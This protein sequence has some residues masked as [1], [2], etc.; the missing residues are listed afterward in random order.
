MGTELLLLRRRALMMADRTVF[1]TL[2]YID[3]AEVSMCCKDGSDGKGGTYQLTAVFSDGLTHSAT[4]TTSDASKATVNGSGLVSFSSATSF[5]DVT[6]S[7]SYRGVTKSCLLTVYATMP[8]YDTFGSG[9]WSC[10][11]G[12]GVGSFDFRKTIDT[13]VPTILH[14]NDVSSVII[15]DINTSI[16]S[17]SFY[18][19]PGIVDYQINQN[20]AS[21]KPCSTILPTSGNRTRNI[22]GPDNTNGLHAFDI[23]KAS[24]GYFIG[25]TAY[26]ESSVSS[27]EPTNDS[28]LIVL[29]FNSIVDKNIKMARSS[30]ATKS[31][32]SDKNYCEFFYIPQNYIRYTDRTVGGTSRVNYTVIPNIGTLGS[33]FDLPCNNVPSSWFG[34]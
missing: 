18:S 25:N 32:L 30:N 7:C 34:V 9:L 27:S 14:I 33:S 21:K 8:S 3:Q 26:S 20:C 13:T 1:P 5:G 17:S 31:Q 22:F 4:W 19:K 16:T 28:G 23:S 24:D 2:L 11:G 6:I 12:C 10:K 29:Y 15:S